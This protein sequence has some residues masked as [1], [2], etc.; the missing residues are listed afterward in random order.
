MNAWIG[1]D[2]DGTLA[3][4]GA[5]GD[6]T[7]L[8]EPVP[9]MVNRVKA[10]ISKGEDVRIFTARVGKREGVNAAGQYADDAFIEKQRELIRAWCVEHLGVA[11]PI[12]AT[13]DF[14]MKYFYD[15][16]AVQVEQNTGRVIGEELA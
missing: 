1:V 3:T 9:A 4:Y 8:G 2:F 5:W 14:G 12:T 10:L 16:R 15:D 13:K 6:G 11:L 7:K